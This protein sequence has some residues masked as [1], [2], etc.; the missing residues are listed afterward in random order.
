MSNVKEMKIQINEYQKLL[1]DLKAGRISL[2]EKF[3]VGILIEKLPDSWN[4][5]KNSLKHKQINFTIEEIVIHILIED[6]NRNESF[7][8]RELTLKANLTQSRKS[9]N[10]R[11]K[12]RND[13]EMRNPPKANLSEGDEII[14]AVISQVNMVAH[15]KEWVIDSGATRHI[16]ANREAFASYTSIGDDSEVVYLGDSRAAKV[17]GKGKMLLKLTSEKTLALV[18]V[19]HVPTMRA[20]LISVTLLDK[21]GMK[22]SIESNKIIFDEK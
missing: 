7:K 2:P 4:D 22:V 5:Y 15:I 16:C 8:V 17:L 21:V 9:N 3:A 18:D 11:H 12:I 19:L 6:I 14:V 10:K 1:E 20:N 13:K